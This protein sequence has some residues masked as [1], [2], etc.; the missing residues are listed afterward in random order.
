MIDLLSAKMD[1]NSIAA[2][3]AAQLQH[4]QILEFQQRY[5]AATARMAAVCSNGSVATP[6]SPSA[7]P[8]Q[9]TVG[10]SKPKVATPEVVG[11]IES[12]KYENP[13]IFA[14]EIREKLISEGI[15]TNNTAPSVS[16]I[17]RIIRNRAAE[18]ATEEFSRVASTFGNF[19]PHTQHANPAHHWPTSIASPTTAPSS[20]LPPLVSISSPHLKAPQHHN[21]RE[22][23]LSPKTSEFDAKS[24]HEEVDSNYSDEEKPQFRRSRSTFTQSQLKCLEKEFEKSHYPDLKTREDLSEK[25]SLSEARI[26]VWFSN[27][28]AKW[29]RHHQQT[30]T[31]VGQ[32]QQNRTL[33][34][35]STISSTA[36][37]IL[38]SLF[39]P[40]NEMINNFIL[41]S[42]MLVTHGSGDPGTPPH[43]DGNLGR[44]ENLSSD[45]GL[46][47]DE[48]QIDVD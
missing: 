12:Y 33:E 18:R 17:N 5:L 45:H 41:Q 11:K 44:T 35:P 16:S 40:Y 38:G 7:R 3:Y 9:A 19:F 26:Q 13:T 1:Q 2:M 34:S 48:P 24:H 22:A 29:R 21:S 39:R 30:P 6:N 27:R 43:R 23:S 25:T 31:S 36:S 20:G 42:R 28:R 37:P 47:Q 8:S 46:Q 14:W 10:G 32:Q 4:R 15:C